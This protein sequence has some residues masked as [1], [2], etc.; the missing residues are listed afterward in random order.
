MLNEIVYEK[1]AGKTKTKKDQVDPYNSIILNC[2]EFGFIIFCFQTLIFF[3]IPSQ[4]LLRIVI[5]KQYDFLYYTILRRFWQQKR[6]VQMYKSS[7]CRKNRFTNTIICGCPLGIP[8][9]WLFCVYK[10]RDDHWSSANRNG[11]RQS[12]ICTD[13]QVFCHPCSE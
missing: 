1:N 10:C 12:Q 4:H 8:T 13:V 5:I 2:T 7:G 11:Y 3:M 9:D 6:L